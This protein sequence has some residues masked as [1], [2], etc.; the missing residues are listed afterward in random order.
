MQA[1]KRR[2][3]K[4]KSQD[5]QPMKR[6]VIRMD[7]ACWSDAKFIGDDVTRWLIQMAAEILRMKESV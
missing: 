1:V 7:D 3:R 2:G 4:P 6:R 5:G